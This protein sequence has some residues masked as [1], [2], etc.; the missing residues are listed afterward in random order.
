[1]KRILFAALLAGCQFPVPTPPPGPDSSDG[2]RTPTEDASTR[3]AG[4]DAGPR[5]VLGVDVPPGCTTCAC[6]CAILG[7]DFLGCPEG[8]PT[9]R[10]ESCTDTCQHTVDQPGFR[11]PTAAVSK[12]RDIEC[13]RRAGVKCGAK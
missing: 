13:V 5:D 9:P 4:A 1:M 6:A 12:C 10:G 7:P 2:G 11:L 3:D 8:N